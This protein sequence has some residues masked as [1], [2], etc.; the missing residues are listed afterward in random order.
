MDKII[1][2]ARLHVARKAQKLSSNQVAELCN[3]APAFIRAIES[4]AKLPSVPR[5]VELCNALKVTP[6]SLLGNELTFSITEQERCSSEIEQ[7]VLR[8][9][10][11]STKKQKLACCVMD[12]LIDQLDLF[13][14]E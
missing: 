12:S 4:G 11:L 10:R 14:Q 13:S 6:N 8:L 9:Q 7:L 2:G 5:L 1:F 3:C